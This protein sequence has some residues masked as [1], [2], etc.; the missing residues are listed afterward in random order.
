M[1][2]MMTAPTT[3]AASRGM[4][5]HYVSKAMASPVGTLTLV[6]SDDGLAAV[7]WENDRPGR[8]PLSI[9]GEELSHPVLLEAERQ[10]REYF[11]GTRTQ[12][13][14]PLDVV[15][16]PFQ[17]QVWE[18]L[19]SIP[20]GETRSYAEIADQIG[21]PRAVRAVGAANGRNPLSIV[22]PCHRV[23]GSSGQLTGFAGG[24]EVKAQLLAFERA[25]QRPVTGLA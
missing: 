5:K 21:S 14:L 16:T 7:L 4:T 13:T 9:R 18:A 17:R 3:M 12:F 23:I 10:L 15:G 25:G 11:G 1:T 20:Y 2:A 8:V 6:A 22:A 24:L 19:R